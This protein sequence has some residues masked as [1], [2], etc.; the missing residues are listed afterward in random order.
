MPLDHRGRAPRQP[1][2]IPIAQRNSAPVGDAAGGSFGT[3]SE[4]V[5]KPVHESRPTKMSDADAGREQAGD[6][7]HAEHGAA[8]PGRPP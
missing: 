1:M 6:E 5:P 4:N 7:D 2:P 3:A 8:E